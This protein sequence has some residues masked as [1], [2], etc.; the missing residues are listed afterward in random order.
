MEALSPKYDPKEVEERWYQ[1]WESSGCFKADPASS[2]PP[3]SVVIPPPNVTGS[4]HIGHALNDSLQDLFIRY[5]RM[6]GFDCLWVPG[7]D[8][9]GIAT[10]NVVERELAKEG[11]RRGDLGR[12]KF[13]ER[14][15]QWKEKSGS[16]IMRQ[17][18][19]LGASCDWG[20]ERFTMDPGLSESVKE[21]FVRLYEAGLIYQ[22][23]YIINWCPRCGTALS[24]IE[25]EHK[26]TQGKLYHI[27]YAV[28]GKPGSFITVATTRP[29][30]LMGD[31]AVCVHP[32]DERYAAFHGATLILPVLGREI[33][34]I[35]DS[36]VDKAF[37]T[38][39]LKI[40]PAHDAN[41][42]AL[43]EKFGLP[44]IKVMD[45]QG[46]MN[47]EAGPYAGLDRFACRKR[48]VADLE[49]QG[50]LAKVEDY[51]HA[52]GHCYRCATVVESYLSRQ[53]FV[54]MKP[55]AE[56][57]L[58]S[59]AAGET[60]FMP[61]NWAKVY[62][63]W[64][65]G[66][67]DW[68]VSRQIWW[69]HRI[70][71]YYAKDGRQAAG[72]SLAEA[73][74]KLGVPE[75]ELA[76]D[77]DV[78]D[79]WFSSGLWPFSTLGWPQPTPELARYYPTSVLVTSWDILFF[80]VARMT[81]FGLQLKG[82]APFR[83]VFINSLVA[84]EHGQK[85]SKSKG[86]VIDP[87][88]KIDVIGADALRYA[89]ASIENQSRYI[90][91]SEERLESGRN[92]MNKIWN[93]ARFVLKNLED[94]RPTGK[95]ERPVCV[96]DLGEKWILAR[97]DK[98]IREV[99]EAY[100]GYKVSLAAEK[101]KEFIWNDFCDWYVEIAKIRLQNQNSRYTSQS[102]LAYV[103]EVSMK[104]LHPICPFIT[105]E[106]W[107]K[108]PGEKGVTI[109]HE[110]WP[111]FSNTIQE[112]ETAK[113]FKDFEWVQE[114]VYGV[115]NL[116]GEYGTDPAKQVEFVIKRENSREDFYNVIE[117]QKNVIQNISGCS[118]TFAENNLSLPRPSGIAIINN[119]E[120]YT[121]LNQLVDL[122]TERLRRKKE[123]QRQTQYVFSLENKFNNSAYLEKAPAEV[124][125]ADK[126]RLEEARIKL[127][128]LKEQVKEIE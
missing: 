90:S 108:I 97:L 95:L 46:V 35:T 127:E 87:L 28:K 22:G 42:F 34:L 52:V 7:C 16:T 115:R 57:A 86:N 88:T 17:L 126:K 82:Q 73:A 54:R 84:D 93:A 21:A 122:N 76:Q 36:Y 74:A 13:I 53:W 60:E 66:I 31:V 109:M 118:F 6:Q 65:E 15:W 47:A 120:W 69:G 107:Q 75:Q 106:I 104:L 110:V 92:F 85:M 38:G 71:V 27:R 55:L 103:L 80:W 124:V 63:D 20:Y 72:R 48:I 117:E 44:R 50:L 1:F 96:E 78:L 19:R 30:T 89:L 94:F 91:L 3:F 40:T 125:K 32:E 2:K 68:C 39:A 61:P 43:G 111:V 77:P 128:K 105:E 102:V 98:T 59:L 18:R 25:A 10:Q 49:A 8:H 14:V 79:T 62:R 113:I 4:L 33:P 81:M 56:K 64:L 58:Q 67:R 24:D 100:E 101:V 83:K 51:Q 12:D 116:K 119:T 11:K 121:P 9:A 99:T 70:P 45:P 23:D 37:G 123:E 29:E 112:N 114:S 41:D 5:K 26:E